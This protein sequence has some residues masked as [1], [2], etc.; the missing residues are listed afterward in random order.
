MLRPRSSLIGTLAASLALVALFALPHP[1]RAADASA[2][3]AGQAKASGNNLSVGG[4]QFRVPAEWKPTQP[5]NSL[6]F[7]Q[8]IAT[9]GA[10]DPVE[11]VVFYF[12]PGRGG[13][14]EENIARWA[15]QF[16][17][18]QGGAVKPTMRRTV[19]NNMLVTRMELSGNYSRG[20]GMGVAGGNLKKGQALWAAI[21]A[22]PFQGNLTFHL[23]G[24]QAAVKQQAKRFESML[25]TMKFTG[26]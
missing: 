5:D 21:V 26:H 24:P 17:D 6:R 23:F 15:S 14:Q 16:T 9:P 20:V 18:D 13:T 4:M 22:T 10:A 8:F 25:K 1:A 12:A 3:T 11:M 2:A 19:V 7:A